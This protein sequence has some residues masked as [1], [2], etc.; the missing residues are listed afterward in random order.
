MA[1]VSRGLN[2]GLRTLIDWGEKVRSVALDDLALP[3][4]HPTL[5]VTPLSTSGIL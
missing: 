2:K 4:S 5:S 1:N 3:V